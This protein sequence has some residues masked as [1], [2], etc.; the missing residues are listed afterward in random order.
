MNRKVLAAVLVLAVLQVAIA[1]TEEE[2]PGTIVGF[3]KPSGFVALSGD[4]TPGSYLVTILTQDEYSL[5]KDIHLLNEQA[6]LLSIPTLRKSSH[7]YVRRENTKG[8]LPRS[9]GTRLGKTKVSVAATSGDPYKVIHVGVDY[10]LL[11][12]TGSKP[13]RLC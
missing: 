11:E 12:T 3:V 4:G 7:D 2:F 9:D 10:L 1:K 6:L 8:K 5:S 13:K